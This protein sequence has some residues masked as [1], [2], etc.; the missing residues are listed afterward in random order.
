VSRWIAALKQGDE[1]AAERIWE[2]YY[3]QLEALCRK[4]LPAS[5]RR[6]SDDE[7][8]ALSTFASLFTEAREGCLPSLTDRSDLWQLLVTIACRKAANRVRWETQ[9]KRGAGR[10]RGESVFAANGELTSDGLD[11]VVGDEPT[12]ET[13]L[14]MAEGLQS[15]LRQLPDA[16]LSEIAMLKLKAYSNGEIARTLDCSLRTVERKLMRIRAIWSSEDEN[17]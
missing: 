16:K 11:Q 3:R 15:L 12:P 17:S 10:T 14:L 1:D 7:D 4:R 13:V 6:V 2:P 9:Q 5:L 8:L